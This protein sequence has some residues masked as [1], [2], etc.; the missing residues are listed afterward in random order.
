MNNLNVQKGQLKQQQIKW[1]VNACQVEKII[2]NN[3]K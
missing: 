2:Y 3:Y 1:K